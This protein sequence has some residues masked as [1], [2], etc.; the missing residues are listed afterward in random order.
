MSMLSFESQNRE[1]GRPS[2]AR[3][4]RLITCFKN[5]SATITRSISFRGTLKS[6]NHLLPQVHE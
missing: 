2:P 3:V 4:Y 6:H 5:T 1:G